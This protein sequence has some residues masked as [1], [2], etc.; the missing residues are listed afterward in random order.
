[1]KTVLHKAENRGYANHGWLETYHSFSFANF[2]DPKKVNFGALRVLNDDTVDGGMGFGMHPHDNMEIITIPLKG[3]LEHKDSM[4][5]TETIRN[6]DVQVMSAGTGIMHS[7]YNANAD[8]PVSLLQIWIIPNQRMVTPRYEQ[9]TLDQSKMQNKLYQVLSPNRDDDGVWIYQN[10]WFHLSQLDGNH[11][12]NYK[13]KDPSN[14]VYLF[15]ID[16]SVKTGDITLFRK[17]GLGLWETTEFMIMANQ[18]SRILLM[19]V[20]MKF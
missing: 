18:N 9:I 10:A 12:I 15:V 14:G 20:P 2:Y 3:D 16:G 6:G 13:L 11:Q 1:M 4:G 5:H 8:E 17:D 7:E 19:E